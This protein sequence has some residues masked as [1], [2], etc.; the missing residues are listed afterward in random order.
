MADQDY[1]NLRE[2]LNT[3]HTW[4]SVYLFKFIVKNEEQQTKILDLFR[5]SADQVQIKAS[6]KGSYHSISIYKEAQDVEEIISLYI[7]ASSIEGVISL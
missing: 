3:M 6:S 5:V 7:G 2:K 1:D 4:P